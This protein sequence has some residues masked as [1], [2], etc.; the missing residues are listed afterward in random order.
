[1][2]GLTRRI[3]WT[4]WVHWILLR[5]YLL[6][7]CHRIASQ[8][9]CP[10]LVQLRMRWIWIELQC[11]IEWTISSLGLLGNTWLP[12]RAS[13]F[14]SSLRILIWYSLVNDWSHVARHGANPLS[15]DSFLFLR[16][17]GIACDSLIQL[18]LDSIVVIIE[19][20]QLSIQLRQLALELSLM[21]MQFFTL[22]LEGPKLVLDML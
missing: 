8:R 7:C 1:M 17:S 15:C 5:V 9:A 3:Q 13:S 18:P 20:H 2:R 21:L 4:L 16:G 14:W 22:L 19:T 12:Q 6:G 10:R 11:S